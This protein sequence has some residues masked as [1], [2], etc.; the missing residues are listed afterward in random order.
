[1]EEIEYQ[2]GL[3]SR[4]ALRGEVAAFWQALSTDE[5]LRREIEEADLDPAEIQRL[6]PAD[7]QVEQEGEPFG[8]VIAILIVF[9]P[10][11]R[12][13]AESLWDDVMLPW[14]LDHRGRDAIGRET[15]RRR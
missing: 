15:K 9:A 7:I 13:V 12:H 5:S 10:T 6:D 1:V 14:I 8:E 11:I 3:A 2:P 4:D